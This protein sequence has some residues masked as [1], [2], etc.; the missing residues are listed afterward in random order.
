[1]EVKQ[2]YD[3]MNN[4]TG[5]VIGKSDLLKEDLSNVVDIGTEVFNASAV[6]KYVKSLVNHIGKVIFVNRP[7]SGNVPSVMMDSWEFGSILEKI[8]ADL[9]TATENESWELTDGTDYSPNVFHQPKV[10][11][12]FF[13]DMITFEIPMS[14]TE[15]QVKQ[16]FSSAAQLNGFMSMLY[17]SVDKAMTV[18]IDSLIM[19]TINNMI[20]ETLL[21][22][23]TTGTGKSKTVADF[24]SKS[25]IKAVNLLKL[26]NDRFSQTLTAE[27]ALTTAEFIR[28]A[29]MQMSLYIDRMSK[30]STLFNAGGKD[31]FTSS[32]MLHVV[33]LTDFKAASGSYLQSDTFHENYVALPNAETIPYWQGSGTAYDFNS[34]SSIN[35][36]TA[37]GTDIQASGIL[38]VM[39]DRDALGVTNLDRRVTTQYNAKAEFFNNFYK[40]EAGYFN[41]LN[42]NFVVFFV[43]DAATQ[44]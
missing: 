5:E 20:A 26:Y 35:I 16:S 36:K 19:R 24:G 40:F 29:S 28:F 38:A 10:S 25:G 41:D 37:S 14:F 39:F 44:A 13:N 43:K 12:K 3:L 7:Y 31:R 22:D 4:V 2:I 33:M 21:A 11:A 34:V 1:M 30:M 18:K 8:S 27:K 23:Y 32:D 6:D 15:R 17:N 42:E 9:P